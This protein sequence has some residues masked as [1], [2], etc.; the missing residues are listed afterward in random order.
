MPNFKDFK[1]HFNKNSHFIKHLGS[2][3]LSYKLGGELNVQHH[4]SKEARF[5]RCQ[6]RRSSLS[7]LD[8]KTDT[9]VN[10]FVA[11]SLEDSVPAHQIKQDLVTAQILPELSMDNV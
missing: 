7:K 8:H 10:L 11:E 6:Q 3:Y 4:R 9:D 1:H 5:L 2:H